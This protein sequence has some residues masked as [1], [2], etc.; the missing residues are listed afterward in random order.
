MELDQIIDGCR[1]ADNRA[2]RELYERYSRIIFGVLCRY[3]KRDQAEDLLHDTFITIFTRIGDFRNEGSFEGWCRRIAVHTAINHLRHSHQFD[4]VDYQGVSETINQLPD[5][6]S[7]PDHLSREEL[8]KTI[9]QLSPI[10]RAIVNLRVVE[11]LDY[12]Q[13]AREMDIKES[14]AR[15]QY[16]RAR[17]QLIE[18]INNEKM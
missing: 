15:S 8:M 13:I 18:L 4:V 7:M 17:A 9:S 5:Q 2:R 3:V 6:T 11:Q 14:T 10:S 1:K 16:R 12:H